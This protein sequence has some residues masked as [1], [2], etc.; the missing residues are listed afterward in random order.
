MKPD[1]A[2]F[3]QPMVWIG[4]AIFAASLAAC[5]ATIVVAGRH[6]DAPVDARGSKV[7]GVPLE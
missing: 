4:G 1:G 7:L 6:V 3:R 5:I 2:W